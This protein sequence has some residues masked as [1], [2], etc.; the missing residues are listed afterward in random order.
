[1][2]V[3]TAPMNHRWG[4]D[5]QRFFPGDGRISVAPML[6]LLAVATLTW[7]CTQ[8]DPEPILD[9]ELTGYWSGSFQILRDSVHLV[10]DLA[11]PDSGPLSARV[12]L[13]AQSIFDLP[14]VMERNGR[15]L[16]FQV[17]AV[18]GRYE[19]RLARDRKSI[20]GDWLQAG[21]KFRLSL[22]PSTS[23]P[24]PLRPQE[25]QPPYPYRTESVSIAH[26]EGG[27]ILAGTLS[28]PLDSGPHP[29]VVLVSGS[30]PQDRD[31]SLFGHRPFLVL[32]H[33]LTRSG[34]AVLRYD[35]RG[36]AESVGDF[37]NA[38]TEDFATD[39]LA[40]VDYLINR[41]DID[42][43]RVGIIGHSEGGIVAPIAATRSQRVA[44]IVSL[45]GTGISGRDLLELQTRLILEA[46]E[47]PAPV[48]A[49]NR[50][51]QGAVFDILMEAGSAEGALDLAK[52]EFEAAW[53]GLP[54]A[55]LTALGLA[56]Q[57]DR[58][59]EEQ[60]R[61]VTSPWFFFFLEF[62]P[63]TAFERVEVPVLA[64]N[65]SLDL[66]VPADPNLRLIREA[67]ARGGNRDVTAVELEGLNHLFQTAT[68][69]LP[70]EYGRI[71]ETM[72]PEVLQLIADWIQARS[73]QPVGERRNP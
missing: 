11:P 69:G 61:K 63:T 8:P 43:N 53:S 73:P 35:D 25:P 46:S 26:S 19:G 27:V 59:L 49:L 29:A 44:F 10:L 65:G 56:A 7:G 41:E 16:R 4:C 66:Q 15:D 22:A 24:R 14:A 48:I 50:R 52:E 20:R 71:E 3:R 1:M 34:I 67:L 47:L 70:S 32:A 6:M 38:T 39:A 5:L 54:S 31:E 18:G 2:A 58:A 33:H 28:V 51:L 40:A 55:A 36:V 68:T 17:T 37:A 12:S 62:D 64:L 72:A 30:G 9:A 45:A 23:S 60:L 13:P 21:G 57:T 42:P